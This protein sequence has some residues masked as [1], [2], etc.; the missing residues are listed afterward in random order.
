MDPNA[1][2]E[3]AGSKVPSCFRMACYD[4]SRES[5]SISWN[6]EAS[7]TLQGGVATFECSGSG[8]AQL[9]TLFFQIT[10]NVRPCAKFENNFCLGFL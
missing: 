5:L 4:F 7:A 10:L 1:D 6:S 3:Q 9:Q 2:D 8:G